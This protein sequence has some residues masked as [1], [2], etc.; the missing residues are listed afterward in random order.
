MAIG[1]IIFFLCQ[2][3]INYNIVRLFMNFTNT[4]IFCL[5]FIS[6]YL[7]EILINKFFFLNVDWFLSKII[8]YLFAIYTLGVFVVFPCLFFSCLLIRKYIK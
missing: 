1:L 8:N 5:V 3:I 4:Y 7:L 6:L 2:Y